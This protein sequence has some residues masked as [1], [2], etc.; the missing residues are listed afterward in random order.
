ML[1]VKCSLIVSFASPC[2]GY[3]M[4]GYTAEDVGTRDEK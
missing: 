2:M 1:V 3:W 4:Q